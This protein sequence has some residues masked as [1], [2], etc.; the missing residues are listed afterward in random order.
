M[1]F[2]AV[3]DAYGGDPLVIANL[4]SHR[5]RFAHNGTDDVAIS[6]DPRRQALNRQPQPLREPAHLQPARA[7]YL[8][9]DDPSP[10]RTSAHVTTA[11]AIAT[12]RWCSSVVTGSAT[13]GYR[14]ATAKRVRSVASAMVWE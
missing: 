1:Q 4:D 5:S 7:P 2:P 11:S 8:G 9:C 6:C 13:P 12:A 10:T 3:V 14:V